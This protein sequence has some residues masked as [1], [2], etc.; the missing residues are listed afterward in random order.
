MASNNNKSETCLA[1]HPDNQLAKP[2]VSTSE[3]KMVSS[4]SMDRVNK[5][6]SSACKETQSSIHSFSS[7]SFNNSKAT[8][9]RSKMPLH[10]VTKIKCICLTSLIKIS[11]IN[12][13]NSN[14]KLHNRAYQVN[15]RVESSPWT[16]TAS[17]KSLSTMAPPNRTKWQTVSSNSPKLDYQP[18]P[19]SNKIT[20]GL[21]TK[22]SSPLIRWVWHRAYRGMCQVSL[23]SR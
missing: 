9:V 10:L 16:V 6:R 8:A 3:D 23:I 19:S 18:V 4:R 14:N 1:T 2:T 12:L 22:W 21:L 20:L 7:S 5:H 15:K 13:S 17:N 11:R